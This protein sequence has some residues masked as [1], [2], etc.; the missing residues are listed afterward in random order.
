MRTPK[1]INQNLTTKLA[2]AT[3]KVVLKDF[4]K[5]CSS[6]RNENTCPI[7]SSCDAG[8]DTDEYI[9]L[10]NG[11]ES[12][13]KQEAILNVGLTEEESPA[14]V[15]DA[16]AGDTAV[17]TVGEL[18]P[19]TIASSMDSS[20]YMLG[21][22]ISVSVSQFDDKSQPCVI[23]KQECDADD[24]D[25]ILTAMTQLEDHLLSINQ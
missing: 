3:L 10:N 23:V 8:S 20:N 12:I 2:T 24:D 1:N 11:S 5:T 17:D 6:S 4:R 18:A 15:G 19:D 7:A 14:V 21:S 25:D 22:V 13:V 9:E 16:V